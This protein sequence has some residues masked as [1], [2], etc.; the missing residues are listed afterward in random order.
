MGEI[1]NGRGTATRS[2]VAS[3]TTGNAGLTAPAGTFDPATDVGRTVG[4]PGIPAGATLTAVAS[5]T[6]ATMSG[7]ATATAANITATLG[8][9][10]LGG[11]AAQLAAEQAFGFRGWS[12]ESAAEA[13]TY[14]MTGG[15]AGGPGASEPSRVT[16]PNT[17]HVR[18]DRRMGG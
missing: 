18:R 12:P 14:Q 13:L 3:T 4:G 16:D 2:V 8:D 9:R 1:V 11:P 6:A 7:P 5:P 15:P 10:Y 17:G